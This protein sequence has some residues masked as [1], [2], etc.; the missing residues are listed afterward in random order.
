MTNHLKKIPIG[1][2]VILALL[3]FCAITPSE[4]TAQSIAIHNNIVYDMAKSLS[5]GTEISL[6]PRTTLELYGS[7]RP[8]KETSSEINKHWLVQAQYRFYTCQKYNGFYWGPYIHGGE[9]NMENPDLPFGLLKGIGG[10]RYEGW[11]VGGGLGI[12]YEFALAKHFNIGIEAG[13]G[14]TYLDFDKYNCGTCGFKTDEGSYNY[15]G[16]SKLGLNLIYLF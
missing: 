14:Y 15:W 10:A 1:K 5:L 7:V 2:A 11:L 12:G 9:Y 8:W 16:V 3:G 4:M 6:K 13:G